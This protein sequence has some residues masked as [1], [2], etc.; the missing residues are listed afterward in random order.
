M[1]LG[2][3]EDEMKKKV[4]LLLVFLLVI[5]SSASVMAGVL[6]SL[7][8][9]NGN[10]MILKADNLN[11][12]WQKAITGIELSEGDKIKSGSDTYARV[13]Y[14][15][16]TEVRIREHTLMELHSETLR[17]LIGDI[18]VQM[19]KRG[20]AFEVHTPSIVAGVRG[21]KFEVSTEYSGDSRVAVSQG[22]VAVSGGGKEIMVPADSLVECQMSGCP[23][24]LR[25]FDG[26]TLQDSWDNS[27]GSDVDVT[28]SSASGRVDTMKQA[29][30]SYLEAQFIFNKAKAEKNMTPEIKN[31]FRKALKDY[32]RIRQ[33][34]LDNK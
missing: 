3:C 1:D 13:N 27:A 10:I 24:E 4:I 26:A 31:K 22:L 7:E 11:F 8:I 14:N 21:T 9:V 15:D 25:E 32:Q 28:Y 5:F 29:K 33:D 20:T 19:I 2:G 6:G 17:L 12:T 30:A 23:G 34:F 16:G 18:W